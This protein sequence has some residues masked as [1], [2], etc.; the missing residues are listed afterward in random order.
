MYVNFCATLSIS[1][2]GLIED[3]WNTIFF[4]LNI[5]QLLKSVR[6]MLNMIH[7]TK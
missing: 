4:A 2:Y 1:K 5:F 7:E 3:I 6:N